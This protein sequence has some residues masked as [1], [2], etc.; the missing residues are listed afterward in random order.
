[1]AAPSEGAGRDHEGHLLQTRL[2]MIVIH[3]LLWHIL[4]GKG[5]ST[6]AHRV[7]CFL[8]FHRRSGASAPF[9]A[10]PATSYEMLSAEL[11]DVAFFKNRHLTAQCFHRSAESLPHVDLLPLLHYKALAPFL[12]CSVSTDFW[13]K[14]EAQT[15]TLG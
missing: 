6:P 11:A 4:R 13:R 14:G 10:L 1:M 9:C 3:R 7:T 2:G 15:C 12:D 8:S 5:L